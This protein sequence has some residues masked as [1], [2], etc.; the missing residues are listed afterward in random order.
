MIKKHTVLICLATSVMLIIIAA[1]NYPGGSIFDNNS[2]GFDWTK[3]FIS[4]LF[5]KKA[6]NGIENSYRIWAIIGMAFNSLG[7]GIFFINMSKKMPSTHAVLVLKVVGA[8]NILFNFLIVTPLHDLMVGISSTLSLLGL[9]YITVFLFKTKLHLLKFFSIICL[10]TFYFT[11]FLYGM[12]NY[13]LLAIMQKVSFLGSMLLILGL[14]Y[15][16]KQEDFE[17]IKPSKQ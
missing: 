2:V 6:I 8:A 10:L 5:E 7:A 1:V 13:V 4:N 15:S 11:L 9:F 17:Q 12:G 3:N 16:T 14:E